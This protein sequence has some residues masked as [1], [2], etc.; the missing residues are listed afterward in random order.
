MTELMQLL[1]DFTMTHRLPQYMDR[2]AYDEVKR[3]EKRHLA[4]L[5]DG[6]SHQQSDALEKYQED[7]EESRSLELRAMFLAAFSAARELFG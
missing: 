2:A 7:W 4:V 3:L 5:R 6:L 1:M